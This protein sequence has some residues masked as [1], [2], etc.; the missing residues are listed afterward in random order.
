MADTDESKEETETFNHEEVSDDIPQSLLSYCQASMKRASVCE[1]LILQDLEDLP[2]SHHVE[3]LIKLPFGLER[4]SRT[5]S[6]KVQMSC[7]MCSETGDSSMQNGGAVKSSSET[8]G[9]KPLCEEV[10][11]KEQRLQRE[12]D[13]QEE[14]RKITETEKLRQLELE[15]I[16]R[17]AQE[18]IEQELLLQQE[19]MGN[20]KRQVE[21][22]RRRIDEERK[23]REK[24]KERQREEESKRKRE[25]ERVRMKEEQS[26]RREED[27]KKREE[28]RRIEGEDKRKKEEEKESKCKEDKQQRKMK[29]EE[30]NKEEEEK[31]KGEKWKKEESKCVEDEQKMG[32]ENKKKREQERVQMKEEQNRGRE[33]DK[34]KR[35]E[36]GKRFEDEKRRWE[37]EDKRKREGR[38]TTDEESEKFKFVGMN[39]QEECDEERREEEQKKKK[40]NENRSLEEE[41]NRDNE[42]TRW[43]KEERKVR[44]SHFRR[45]EMI[46]L[47]EEGEKK[48]KGDA[49]TEVLKNEEK[50]EEKER[51]REEEEILIQVM[52]ITK[53]EDEKRQNEKEKMLRDDMRKKEEDNNKVE[54]ER[55]KRSAEALMRTDLKE[56]R[57]EEEEKQKVKVWTERT[58]MDGEWTRQE[59]E[60]S[61]EKDRTLV[62]EGKDQKNRYEEMIQSLD[63]KRLELK[64]PKRKTNHQMEKQEVEIRRLSDKEYRKSEEETSVHEDAED[65]KGPGQQTGETNTERQKDKWETGARS[66]EEDVK[67]GVEKRNA[68]EEEKTDGENRLIE[69]TGDRER[70]D[71]SDEEEMMTTRK[72][73]KE[74]I[75]DGKWD[76]SGSDP[77]SLLSSGI[78]SDKHICLTSA[79]EAMEQQH[80]EAK[81]RPSSC[82]SPAFLP[83]H[84]EHKRLSWMTECVSWSQ[85]SLQNRRKQKRSAW[86]SRGRRRVAG[87]CSPPPLCPH[88]L[89]RSSGWKSLQ[90]VTTLTLED[91]SSCC[92]STL[93]QCH[94]LRSLTLRRCGLRS[95]EGISQLKDL[96]FVDLQ[97]NDISSVDC[98]NMT[99]LR[100]LQLSHNKLK[101]IHGLG[102]AESLDVLDLSYNS[103]TRIAGLESAKRLQK[104]LVHHNQLISTK[105]LRDVY[106]LLHLD[107]SHN[108]LASVEGLDGSALLHTL[109]LSSNSLSEPPSLNNQVLLRTLHLDDNSIS[110]LQGLAG[111]WLPLLQ[112]L[113]AS[114]NRITQLPN[115][116]DFVSL[117]SLDVRFN[118]LSELQNVCESLEGCHFLREALLSGNPVEQERGWRLALHRA[119]PGLRARPV[120]L[121]PFLVFCQAQLQQTLALQQRHSS[122]LSKAS[123][124]TLE[125]HCWYLTTAL[126][127]AE[128]HR[129]AHENG[130]TSEVL[131]KTHPEMGC[132]SPEKIADYPQSESVEASVIPNMSNIKDRHLRFR[133]QPV[134]ENHH[135]TSDTTGSRTKSTE[136]KIREI[137]FLELDEEPPSSVYD[138]DL[139]DRAA[140]VIQQRWRKYKQKHGNTDA[141][142]IMNKG[143][144]KGKV[145]GPSFFSRSTISQEH[146]AAVIQA[147]WRGFIV[148]R[149]LA[150][151]LAAVMCLDDGE[152]DIL[153]EVDMEEFVFDEPAIE[154]HWKVSISD[155]LPPRHHIALEQ[156]VAAKSPVTE[157]PLQGALQPP[158]TWIPKQAWMAEQQDELELQ[159][160]PAE[161]FNRSQ[162]PGSVSAHC[163]LSETSEK[164]LEEWGFTD[165]RTALLMLK[166]AQKMK[167]A[168]HKQKLRV[169]VAELG[170]QQT[171]QTRRQHDQRQLQ[172]DAYQSDRLSDREPFLPGLSSSVLSGG[173]VQLVADSSHV[174]CG[175]CANT[176]PVS[177][178]FKL[179]TSPHRHILGHSMI[180]WH[181]V[182]TLRVRSGD[183]LPVYTYTRDELLG[184]QLH[185]TSKPFLDPELDATSVKTRKRGCRAG[186]KVKN[187]RRGYKPVLP[188][189]II[190]NVRS[191]CNKVDE[192]SAC[193]RYDRMYR[194]SSLMCFS[195]SWLS[196][197]IPESHVK[198]DGF[199]LRRMDRDLSVT[200]KKQGGGVCTYVNERWCHPSHVTV[201][202]RVCDENVELLVVSCRPYY[203]P[204]EISHIIVTVVYIP[205]SANGKRAIETVSKVTHKLQSSSLD[206]LFIITGDFNHCS[207]SSTL[208]SFRQMV[209]CPMRGKR[210]IDLFYTNIKDGFYSSAL[211]PLGNSDHNLVLLR[212]RY[213]P[214]VQ[215][216][217]VTFR[218][219][220]VWTE[221]A[222]ETLRGCFECTDWSVFTE[223]CDCDDVDDIA[224][225]VTCYVNFCTDLVLPCKQVKVFA[226]NK[227]WVTRG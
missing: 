168:K 139:K 140:G 113:S 7:E 185:A 83:E 196:E 106:T 173:R 80:S 27:R 22:E 224:D 79:N 128:D 122:E 20:L 47:A 186:I 134:E 152:D 215:K 101:S 138:L 94:H 29:E 191:L 65:R 44:D 193:V 3:G 38:K 189:V 158:P 35:D 121:D 167:S 72:N 109:D 30:K 195:E 68:C 37:E 181:P 32:E 110:S 46:G 85:L 205:P 18:K 150:S 67:L 5:Q 123:S 151:A 24:E 153:E 99:G 214:A 170:L 42:E 78:K 219:M 182:Q 143:G 13:F 82:F 148:R 183:G 194:Q 216:Q 211:P 108:H 40:R 84:T 69:E 226:N 95:V 53:R 190:G 88:T 149:R 89:L 169:G 51:K 8:K 208:P 111:C 97:E 146:A 2:V 197:K 225:T 98:E 198:I 171:K 86:S 126:Q 66:M 132:A 16:R 21:Q 160:T 165:R 59:D 175:P 17:G 31:R 90:E 55:E 63:M 49:D 200:A 129:L 141:P 52:R 100:V 210:I 58:R 14:L 71:E 23:T 76:S 81:P 209:K 147:F 57:T 184:L 19:L 117:E 212:S 15:L 221:E 107:C 156:S 60:C 4:D 187:R 103:I 33:E 62:K 154:E 64:E 174:D 118:C 178:P 223:G 93:L 50:E 155:D 125:T 36:E 1:G 227:P 157:L 166:R 176:S 74:K 11:R 177:R 28:E 114:Q 77:T 159:P 131:S 188:S 104:L 222:C 45:E 9:E 39:L 199:T 133:D 25:E 75:R 217:P 137:R 41:R 43:K 192:L 87:A 105:G 180:C 116:T 34:K 144:D 206:A 54:E 73:L 26:R 70:R 201:K 124:P 164:I 142:F 120:N 213:T 204:R 135:N 115:L 56:M 163:G 145:V 162:P 92:L 102:G 96:C 172:T 127:L 161:G 203:L 136:P 61:S 10:Q 6:E 202:E 48:K 220:R 119:L 112:H 12:K 179:N 91:L 130:H 218:A 207:L